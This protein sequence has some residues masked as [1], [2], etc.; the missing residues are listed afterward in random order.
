MTDSTNRSHYFWWVAT[1]IVLTGLGLRLWDLGGASLWVDEVLTEMRAQSSLDR[2]FTLI[3]ESG[4]QTPF[5]F[6]SLHLF[7]THTEFLLRLPSAIIGV[8]GIVALMFVTDRLY[9]NAYMTLWVG[10][11]LAFNPLHILLSRTAR[12]YTYLF[13]CSL[14]ASYF[15]LVLLQGKRT[16]G[17]WLGFVLFS[18]V[19]YLTHYFSVA[20]P[21]AQYIVFAFVLRHNRRFFRQWLAAQSVAVVPILIWIG[22]LLRRDVVSAGIG[23]IPEPAIQDVFLTIWNMT[24]GYRGMLTW[25]A[26]PALV[27]IAVGLLGGL[28]YAI[29][30][31]QRNVV[32]WYWFWLF[33]IPLCL[34]LIAS[35]R[36]PVYVDR[37][38]MVLLPALLLLVVEGWHIL[39]SV[40]WQNLL[41]VT[42]IVVQVATILVIFSN[43]E[44]YKEDWRGAADYVEQHFQ[45]GDGL[46]VETPV[47]LVAFQRY[48]ERDN[49]EYA[50]LDSGS[51]QGRTPY[52]EPVSRIWVMY[53]RGRS[54][55][56]MNEFALNDFDPYV[57]DRSLMSDWLITHREKILVQQDFNSIKVFL[58]D[59]SED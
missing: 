15:F 4:N 22:A 57:A 41:A 16:R 32:N 55:T 19:A 44:N 2:S 10:A 1:G 34:V 23:W 31:R 59:V 18:M 39:K 6:I 53:R 14:M 50:W 30:E 3:M 5:Y 17:N 27:S 58:V 25:Y 46:L 12:P 51:S 35:W 37:Y 33:V 42:V 24:I 36:V 28:R 29:R 54:S 11:L 20:L 9:Q 13:V 49:T 45:A 38:F 21:M 47:E 26:L 8:T 48:F 40:R 43:R 7:P 56:H 52:D